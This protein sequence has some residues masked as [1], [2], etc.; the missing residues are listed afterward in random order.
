[1]E[2][3]DFEEK[4]IPYVNDLFRSKQYNVE[5]CKKLKNPLSE[6]LNIDLIFALVKYICDKKVI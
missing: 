3:S 1:M 2:I 5:I 4:V 6:C